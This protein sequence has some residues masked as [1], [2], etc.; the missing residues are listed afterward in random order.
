MANQRDVAKLAGVSSASVSRFLT[1]PNLVTPKVAAAVERA[2][3]TLNYRLDHSAQTLKTGKS[4]HVGLLSPALGS[5]H[6]HIFQAVENQLAQEGYYCTIF[7]TL[8]PDSRR[9]AQSRS[10]LPIMRGKQIDGALF[11]PLNTPDDDLTIEQ[12]RDWGHP[13][14]ILDRN[15]AI[16]GIPQVV[17]DNYNAGRLAAKKFL[18]LGHKDFLFIWGLQDFPSSRDRFAGFRDELRD[19]GIPLSFDR[20]LEGDFLASHT[21]KF[22]RAL[23]SRLPHFTAVFAANDPSAL[24]FLKASREEGL[25]C[26]RDFSLIG[27]DDD[28]ELSSLVGFPLASFRQPVGELGIRGAQMLLDLL[29]ERPVDPSK[30]TL[31][32]EFIERSS[33]APPPASKSP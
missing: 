32:V 14:V 22:T 33:L 6:S 13:Y 19:A 27:F 28:E 10:L 17:I 26:P 5:Y 2:I 23:W 4:F 20:Q 16:P 31:G 15:L 24:G 9:A 7:D 21:Y 18:A 29:H 1:N 25:D 12:L 3:A 8:G 11:L 30:I